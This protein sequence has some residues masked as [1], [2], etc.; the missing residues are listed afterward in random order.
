MGVLM[1]G[2]MRIARKSCQ[3][4]NWLTGVLLLLLL[5]LLLLMLSP[6]LQKQCLPHAV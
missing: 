4:P 6:M 2:I 5:L 1:H 3:R